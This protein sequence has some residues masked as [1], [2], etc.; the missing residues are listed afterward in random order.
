ME[1]LLKMKKIMYLDYR[2][3]AVTKGYCLG[4]TTE[5]YIMFILPDVV[6]E[7][8]KVLT[9]SFAIQVISQVCIK[10]FVEVKESIKVL[11]FLLVLPFCCLLCFC[12]SKC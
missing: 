7:E 11:C 10:I 8:F 5:L 4:I 3:E 1:R 12:G 2:G 9:F 6:L